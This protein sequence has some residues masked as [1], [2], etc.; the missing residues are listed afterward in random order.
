MLEHKNT[1]IGQQYAD[2]QPEQEEKRLFHMIHTCACQRAKGIKK[3]ME[4]DRDRNG[5]AC[6]AQ[7]ADKQP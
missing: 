2:S 4:Q 1:R 5:T 6:F 3:G 7:I